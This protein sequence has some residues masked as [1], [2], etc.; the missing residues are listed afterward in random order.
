MKED[1]K[2]LV[3]Y[4]GD[5]SGT[6]I[7]ISQHKDWFPGQFKLKFYCNVSTEFVYE[8]HFTVGESDTYEG[9]VELLEEIQQEL[10]M[11][12]DVN[13]TPMDKTA[14]IKLYP[15]LGASMVNKKKLL[16]V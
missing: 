12:A 1:L 9:Y 7:K 14:F 16:L 10:F 3:K 11:E 4:I 2:K 5:Y 13:F 8:T 6:T 15:S